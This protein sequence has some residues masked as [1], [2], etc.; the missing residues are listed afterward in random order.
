MPA[1]PRCSRLAAVALV[2]NG[3][4]SADHCSSGTGFNTPSPCSGC[5]LYDLLA[6]SFDV[7]PDLCGG[8][9]L[10]CRDQNPRR[11]PGYPARLAADRSTTDERGR[12][13]AFD[14]NGPNWL[15]QPW[16]S[17]AQD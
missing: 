5:E 2:D 3:P 15:T 9:P 13:G 16:I 6:N 17:L 14:P 7:R 4:T 1:Y 8:G 11:R 10:G 12:G